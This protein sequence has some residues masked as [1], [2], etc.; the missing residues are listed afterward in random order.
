MA[1]LLETSVFSK[2]NTELSPNSNKIC[3]L[4]F[5]L[6]IQRPAQVKAELRRKCFPQQHT[7]KTRSAVP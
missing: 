2:E 5:P 6:R 1:H 7:V 4:S 3:N